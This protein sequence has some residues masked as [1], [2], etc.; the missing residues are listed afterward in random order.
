MRHLLTSRRFLPLFIS[1]FLGAFNDNLF[2][3]AFII[4]LT[5]VLAQREG[6]DAT[7]MVTIASGL[8]ILPF[9]L[10]SATAGKLADKLEKSTL[11]RYV[12]LFEIVLALCACVAFYMQHLYGLLS[13]LFLLGVQSAFFG[14]LKYS[15][16]PNHLKPDDL[17]QGNGLIET[18]TFLAILIGTLTGGLL[19]L[20]QYGAET[21]SALMLLLAFAGWFASGWIPKAPPQAPETIHLSANIM[22]DTWSVLKQSAKQ[23]DVFLAIIGIS[24][25]W[26]IG[27]T[28]LAQF[29]AFTK[30]ILLADETVVTVFLSIFS[31]GIGIGSMLCHKLTKGNVT[32]KLAAPAALGMALFTA[33]MCFCVG[34]MPAP[35]YAYHTVESFFA[36]LPAW[37]IMGS[38]LA[39]AVCGGIYIVPLYAIMQERSD[40]SAC[41]QVIAGN[42]IINALFMVLSALFTLV[43]LHYGLDITH[44]FLIT[45]LM[46]CPVAILVQ[47]IVRLETSKEWQALLQEK[48]AARLKEQKGV[49]S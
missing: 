9:F 21:V 34:F 15:I 31:I 28:F 39:V 2:K 4:L 5:Y 17:L 47:R 18:G 40:A 49:L 22:G 16:L 44:L 27:A 35:E 37:G 19:I 1:Q 20:T 46:N 45:A 38:L 32:G 26:F 11:I 8:F 42:N 23:Y 48:R 41:A 13:I 14:P 43:G 24:W 3:N 10:F 7:Q 30:D 36:N 25:F 6:V 33:A 12:K 29:P